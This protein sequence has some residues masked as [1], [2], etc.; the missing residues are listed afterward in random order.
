MEGQADILCSSREAVKHTLCHFILV[1]CLKTFKS[2]I[3]IRS[4]ANTEYE[5]LQDSPSTPK[6]VNVMKRKKGRSKWGFSRL[7]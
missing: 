1:F 7:K 3:I 4:Q 5:T 6:K 2:S